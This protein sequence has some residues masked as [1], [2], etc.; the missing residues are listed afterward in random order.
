MYD[1]Q[2]ACTAHVGQMVV[3]WYQ[4]LPW[5]SYRTHR[6]YSQCLRRCSSL[7]V[8]A[9]VHSEAT[10]LARIHSGNRR[11]C[12]GHCGGELWSPLWLISELRLMAHTRE[13]AEL[14]TRADNTRFTGPL[15]TPSRPVSSIPG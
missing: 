6:H 5:K 1:K 7:V 13:S 11:R 10:A 14:L 4:S 3:N 2:L 15:P 12:C 8:A 9:S